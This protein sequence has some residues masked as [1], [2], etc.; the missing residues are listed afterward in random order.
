MS[1][2]NT[3]ARRATYT[4][5]EFGTITGEVRLDT[6]DNTEYFYANECHWP[7]LERLGYEPSLNGFFIDEE[8]L[9]QGVALEYA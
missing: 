3:P 4:H 2:A 6:Y 5:Y 7:M 9:M 1:N 8:T